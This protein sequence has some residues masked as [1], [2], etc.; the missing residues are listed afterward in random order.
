L[1]EPR[2]HFRLIAG[3]AHADLVRLQTGD[4]S[5]RLLRSLLFDIANET[6]SVGN[7]L[8]E[9]VGLVEHLAANA[10][11]IVTARIW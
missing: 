10:H 8:A 7:F 11:D 2:H 3:I 5:S 1:G 9:V 6:G 4:F